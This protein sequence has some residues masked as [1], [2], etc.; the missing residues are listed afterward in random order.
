MVWVSE[1]R[2]KFFEITALSI[3]AGQH[4]LIDVVVDNDA[5]LGRDDVDSSGS[6]KSKF[7]D[8]LKTTS[9]TGTYDE[10]GSDDSHIR[11]ER[12]NRQSGGKE[13][14]KRNKEL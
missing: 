14:N 11:Q 6:E 3:A 5:N 8:K 10:E 4:I 7:Y 2:R 12:F 9:N 13:E 1:L